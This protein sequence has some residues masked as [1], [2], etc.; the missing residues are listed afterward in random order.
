MNLPLLI[1]RG[2]LS[3]WPTFSK[4]MHRRSLGMLLF[5]LVSHIVS[6]PC[7]C[8]EYT[9]VGRLVPRLS[10]A[11]F[12]T[13]VT[14]TKGCW[15]QY[16]PLEARPGPRVGTSRPI[17]HEC[18]VSTIQPNL[19]TLRNVPLVSADNRTTSLPSLPSPTAHPGPY[20]L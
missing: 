16:W 3:C 15:P 17:M 20:I 11:C 9:G 19:M 8:I 14:G 13:E 10:R 7:R 6:K 4:T 5:S 18:Y 2:M 12:I 1:S